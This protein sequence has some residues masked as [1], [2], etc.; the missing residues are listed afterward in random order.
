MEQ[1]MAHMPEDAK[2]PAPQVGT[3]DTQNIGLTPGEFSKSFQ[4]RE[5]VNDIC[6]MH[7]TDWLA[8]ENELSQE[9]QQ[10]VAVLAKDSGQPEST[11]IADVYAAAPGVD[12][13][14]I[15]DHE[16]RYGNLDEYGEPLPPLGDLNNGSG[17]DDDWDDSRVS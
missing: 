4:Y 15:A 1:K 10:A 3:G 11:V 5:R 13:A 17:D 2:L 8:A 9:A 12:A 6:N 7:D 16:D 14:N